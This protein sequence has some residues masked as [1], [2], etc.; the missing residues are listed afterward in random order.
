MSDLI[1]KG[2]PYC[3]VLFKRHL[4]YHSIKRK[5]RT[6]LLFTVSCRCKHDS[7]RVKKIEVFLTNDMTFK[8]HFTDQLAVC[9]GQEK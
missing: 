7:C 5:P 6:D 9:T 2:N 3:T 1:K 4:V 8:V